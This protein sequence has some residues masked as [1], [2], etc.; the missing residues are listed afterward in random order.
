MDLLCA[1][2]ES[3]DVLQIFPN[4]YH[5]TVEI[6]NSYA[7]ANGETFYVHCLSDPDLN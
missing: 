5:I 4:I 7:V 2:S 6:T 3:G 1:M